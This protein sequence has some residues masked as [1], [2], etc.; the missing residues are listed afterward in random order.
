M[1]EQG[2][3]VARGKALTSSAG[4]HQSNINIFQSLRVSPKRMPVSQR[5]AGL[6]GARGWALT[7]SPANEVSSKRG[8]QQKRSLGLERGSDASLTTCVTGSLPPRRISH[9][10]IPN[11]MQAQGCPTFF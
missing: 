10:A 8:L 4:C 1:S 9:D 2:R 11:R 7:R 6:E 3:R 5:T